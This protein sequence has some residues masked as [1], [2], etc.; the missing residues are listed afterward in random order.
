MQHSINNF[1]AV[2][3]SFIDNMLIVCYATHMEKTLTIKQVEKILGMS[4]PT[5]L[6]FAQEHGEQVER[7][8]VVPAEAVRS[9]LAQRSFELQAQ[10]R[11]FDELTQVAV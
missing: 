11:R 5:A 10:M 8:W 9:V 7:K 6:Q 2:V 1:I 4:Y 3:K